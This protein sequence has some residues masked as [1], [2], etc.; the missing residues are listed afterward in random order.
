MQEKVVDQRVKRLCVWKS[1]TIRVTK[2]RLLHIAINARDL[3]AHARAHT[4]TELNPIDILSTRK[5]QWRK[6]YFVTLI[7]KS[8]DFEFK[9]AHLSLLEKGLNWSTNLIWLLLILRETIQW[10]VRQR[11][12]NQLRILISAINYNYFWLCFLKMNLQ[13]DL[14]RLQHSWLS[15]HVSQRN[16]RENLI[17]LQFRNVGVLMLRRLWQITEKRKA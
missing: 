9:A 10:H 5:L 7:E 1:D 11:K 12:R 17:F 15:R 2:A 6:S 4:H 3:N 16:L 13:F 14:L 8:E